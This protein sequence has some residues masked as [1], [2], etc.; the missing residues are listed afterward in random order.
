MADRRLCLIRHAKTGHGS[1]DIGRRLTDRGTRDARA[2]GRWLAKN[3]LVPDRVLVSPA[4]RARETWATAVRE[5]PATPT[6]QI[7]D[8]IYDNTV[9]DLLAAIR[10]ID[11]EVRTLAVVGHNPSMETLADRLAGDDAGPIAIEL[12]GGFA[13]SSVAVF[14]VG[15][16]WTGVGRARAT[17]QAFTVAR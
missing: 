5:L 9:E 4:L 12:R 13:T 10:G 1:P 6:L 14:G 17:V 7:D 8:R 2:L 3:Q 16:D 15:A 11:S